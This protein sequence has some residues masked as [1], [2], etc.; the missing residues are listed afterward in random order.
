MLYSLILVH[1]LHRSLLVRSQA[2]SVPS[3]DE[4]IQLAYADAIRPY[5]TEA[6]LGKGQVLYVCP[7]TQQGIA[8]GQWVPSEVTNAQI[9]TIGDYL[10]PENTPVFIPGSGSYIRTL[11][12]YVDDQDCEYHVPSLTVEKLSF[13]GQTGSVRFVTFMTLWQTNPDGRIT[14]QTMAKRFA[15]LM[16]LPLRTVQQMRSLRPARRR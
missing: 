13:M 9:Y 7:P 16:L 5:L 14:I 15:I 2:V 1:A 10:L 3:G 6:P 12:T 11:K 8:G 4:L